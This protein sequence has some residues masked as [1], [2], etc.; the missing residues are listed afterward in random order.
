[1][2][3]V[4]PKRRERSEVPYAINAASAIPWLQSI[5]RSYLL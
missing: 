4:T 2:L 3:L 5:E 1:M